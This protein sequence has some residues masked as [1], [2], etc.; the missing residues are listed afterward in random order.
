MAEHYIYMET[1]LFISSCKDDAIALAK[2]L[3]AQALVDRIIT[4]HRAGLKFRVIICQENVHGP[5]TAGALQNFYIRERVLESL[6]TGKMSIYQR[7][8]AAGIA[9]PSEYVSFYQLASIEELSDGTGIT[10]LR[11]DSKLDVSEKPCH[12][13]DALPDGQ[14]KQA[15][16]PESS[17]EYTSRPTDAEATFMQ[18]DDTIYNRLV[19]IPRLEE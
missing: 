12:C 10:I 11:T 14:S 5:P 8:R 13:Y 7:L 15:T 16:A 17:S 6:Y 1:Q 19:G 3:V 4:K 18:F 2:N 9:N